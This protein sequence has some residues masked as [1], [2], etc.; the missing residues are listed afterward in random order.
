MRVLS[1]SSG[2]N[3]VAPDALFTPMPYLFRHLQPNVVCPVIREP[4]ASASFEHLDATAPQLFG[5]NRNVTM[6][7]QLFGR[8]YNTFEHSSDANSDS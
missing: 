8:V 2:H 4:F 6:A 3:F 5:S 7:P 1:D